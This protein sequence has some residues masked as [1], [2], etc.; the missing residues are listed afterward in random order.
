MALD[1]GRQSRSE[2]LDPTQDRSAA[3]VHTAIGQETRDALCRGTQLQ[4]VADGEQDDV[5]WEPMARNKAQRL[6]RGMPA[7]GRA[8]V[9]DPATLIVA[10]ASEV[11]RGAAGARTERRYAISPPQANVAEPSFS[12]ST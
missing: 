2:L 9:D 6:S 3:Y 7:T 4:V 12:S 8:D 1:F 11:G 10:I 5:A